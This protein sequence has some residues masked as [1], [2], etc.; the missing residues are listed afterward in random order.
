VPAPNLVQDVF[1]EESTWYSLAQVSGADGV[2]ILTAGV[3]SIDL[4]VYDRSSLTPNTAV[5]TSSITPSTVWFDTFQLGGAGLPLWA[6]DDIGYNFR[7]AVNS[8]AFT[9]G[10]VGGHAYRASYKVV[11]VSW[12]IV[13]LLYDMTCIPVISA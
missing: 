6:K 12:G 5:L 9:G 4:A 2:I 13:W 10:A 8:S 3:T 1:V 7:H 11:T